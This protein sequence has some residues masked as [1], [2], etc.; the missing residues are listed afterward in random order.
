MKK[1]KKFTLNGFLSNN[2]VLFIVSVLISLTIWIYMSYGTSNDTNVTVSGIPIQI[3][4]SDEA[5]NAGL[6]IFSGQEQ[7]A[8]VTVTGNRGTLGAIKESDI[9]VTAAANTIDSAGDYSLPVSAA[10]TNPTSTFQIT[11]AVVPSSIKVAVDYFREPSFQL[12]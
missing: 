2:K 6:M 11:S 8:S 3:E 7:T 1:S 5:M 10:K 4:L 12:Q 9:T